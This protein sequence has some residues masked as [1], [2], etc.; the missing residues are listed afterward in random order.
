MT[1]HSPTAASWQRLGHGIV[2]ALRA[3]ASDLRPLD[4]SRCKPRFSRLRLDPHADLAAGFSKIKSPH[5]GDNQ[6]G[7]ARPQVRR[8]NA[9]TTSEKAGE[10]CRLFG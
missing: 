1:C 8:R 9:S 6:A 7:R 4:C 10:G 3:A 2:W 5:L